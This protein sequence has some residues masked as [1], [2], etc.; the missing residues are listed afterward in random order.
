MSSHR[1][2]VRGVSGTFV[3]VGFP[4]TVT[5]P[6]A[7][8]GRNEQVCVLRGR[9]IS[10][11]RWKRYVPPALHIG[12]RAGHDPR[13]TM[14]SA[15]LRMATLSAPLL[16]MSHVTKSRESARIGVVKVRV[17]GVEQGRPPRNLRKDR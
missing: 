11:H 12:C 5:S 16:A 10:D 2:H 3:A 1:L 9:T 13:V 7:L 14:A 17:R 4:A 6:R 15:V 8:L